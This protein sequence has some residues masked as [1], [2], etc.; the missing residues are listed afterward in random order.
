MSEPRITIIGLGLVGGSMGLALKA[1]ETT[2]QVV[3]HDVDAGRG[4]LAQKMGAV[5]KSSTKLLDACQDANLVVI[6]TPLDAI[7]EILTDIGPHLKQGCIVTDTTTLKEPVLA[8]A[9]EILPD[10][11]SFVGGNPVLHPVVEPGTPEDESAPAALQGLEAARAD[12]FQDVPYA[13]CPSVQA[14]PG[15]VKGIADVVKL[16]GARPYFIDPAEHDGLR[17]AVAELP[18]LASLALMR[19]VSESS[20]WREARKLADHTFAIA[21][22]LLMED[23]T[24]RSEQTLLNAS[25]LLPRLDALIAE[26]GQFRAWI[27]AQDAEAL[28]QAFEQATEAR[29]EWLAERILGEQEHRGA[30]PDFVDTP[31]FFNRMFGFGSRAPKNRKK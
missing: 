5:D 31:G 16:I 13:L 30:E 3:G 25:Y 17:A 14:T 27:E 7:R 26:L 12:L 10:E 28:E 29:N 15:A 23:A 20:G 11:V 1:S 21:T 8:W 22:E 19:Q 4:K 6:A 9:A 24:V 18:P 2:A